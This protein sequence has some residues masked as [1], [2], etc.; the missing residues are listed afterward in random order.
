MVE[1]RRRSCKA[2]GQ[3]AGGSIVNHG[4]FLVAG[5]VCGLYA[6]VQVG[7]TDDHALSAPVLVEADEPQR[8]VRATDRAPGAA[9]RARPDIGSTTS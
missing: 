4:V 2:T 3:A 1:G 8:L 6:R 7:P 5:Q 9:A